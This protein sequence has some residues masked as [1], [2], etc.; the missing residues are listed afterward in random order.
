MKRNLPVEHCSCNKQSAG[1]SQQP[2]KT[3]AWS[4]QTKKQGSQPVRITQMYHL[5]HLSYPMLVTI[6]N[7][8]SKRGGNIPQFKTKSLHSALSPAMLPRAHTALK[9]KASKWTYTCLQI[10]YLHICTNS[11][12]IF[13]ANTRESKKSQHNS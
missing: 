13:T 7:T 8:Y 6:C 1:T 12:H 2:N 10:R 11:L 5:H 4:Y 9:M 3:E